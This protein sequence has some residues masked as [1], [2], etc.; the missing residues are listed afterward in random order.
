MKK[1]ILTCLLIF[2]TSCASAPIKL[3]QID[4][5]TLVQ[6][7]QYGVAPVCDSG[8]LK[9]EDCDIII[10]GL[11]TLQSLIKND[12]PNSIAYIKQ[13]VGYIQERFPV[14]VPYLYWL[15]KLTV[16]AK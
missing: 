1:V 16:T 8:I 5:L 11:N 7:A 14:T 9:K 2:V 15:T 4:W 10:G 13:T 12:T 3:N 6:D